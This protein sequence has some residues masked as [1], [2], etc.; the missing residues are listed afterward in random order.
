MHKHFLKTWVLTGGFFV[1]LSAV[2]VASAKSA[3]NPLSLVTGMWSAIQNMPTT[4]DGQNKAQFMSRA[5]EEN[6]FFE[7]FY[8][9][10]LQDHWES[11]GESEKKAFADRFRILFVDSLSD[12][13]GKIFQQGIALAAKGSMQ[14]AE[15]MIQSFGVKKGSTSG[16]FRVFLF[17]DER[18]WKIYD[19]EIEGVL[20]SRN[21]RAQFNRIIRNEGFGG[22]LARFDTKLKERENKYEFYQF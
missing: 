3:E 14:T 10:A 18:T 7:K 8:Q 5:L 6:F 21:Y 12:H 17:R 20:L 9:T 16:D 2:F 1:C 13:M 11:L 4:N 22:L 15:G 19:I